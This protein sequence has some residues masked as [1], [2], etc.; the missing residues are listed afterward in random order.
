VHAEAGA[1]MRLAG[2][3]LALVIGFRWL[4]VDDGPFRLDLDTVNDAL[5]ACMVTA[6]STCAHVAKSLGAAVP[7]EP[8]AWEAWLASTNDNVLDVVDMGRFIAAS[9]GVQCSLIG[10][11]RVSAANAGVTG[12]LPV[13]Q[14]WWTPGR[15]AAGTYARWWTWA[16][17]EAACRLS[18]VRC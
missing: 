7:V 5:L 15:R 13:Q 16:Q 1:Y 12:E 3:Y 17:L 18:S 4:K 10:Y 9:L 6:A 14:L 11:F 2:R 8:R